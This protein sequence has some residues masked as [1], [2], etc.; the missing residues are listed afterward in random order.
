MD[1]RAVTYE[2][3]ATLMHRQVTHQ[4]LGGKVVEGTVVA[5]TVAGCTVQFVNGEKQKFLW[6]QV[7]F[8]PTPSEE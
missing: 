7:K 1:I 4:R 5:T 2:N 3:H 8:K 6:G